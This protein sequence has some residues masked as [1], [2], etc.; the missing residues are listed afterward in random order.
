MKCKGVYFWWI[1]TR[2][3][4]NESMAQVWSS[5][6]AAYAEEAESGGSRG[7]VGEWNNKDLSMSARAGEGGLIGES[8]GACP[9]RIGSRTVYREL[10][11]RVH[12]YEV[13]HI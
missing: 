12:F 6:P 3:F 2:D 1:Q 8:V 10:Q 7:E 13:F 11:E 9:L 5:G 4:N